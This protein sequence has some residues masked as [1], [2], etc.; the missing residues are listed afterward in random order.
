MTRASGRTWQNWIA[1]VGMVALVL[2]GGWW[3][4]A[5]VTLRFVSAEET[6]P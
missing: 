2:L 3:W 5:A 6:S 4:R 1:G